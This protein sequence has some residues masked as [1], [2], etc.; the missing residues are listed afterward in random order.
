MLKEYFRGNEVEVGLDEA[1]RGCLCGPVCVAA[2]ILPQ[3]GLRDPP[4]EIK[5]SKK[6]SVKKRGIIRKYLEDNVMYSVQFVGPDIIDEINILQATMKGMHRCLDELCEKTEIE[7][8]LVDGTYFPIYHHKRTFDAISHECFAGG[9]N[10]YQSI[11]AASILAKEYRD[12]YMR[13][14]VE[15]NPRLQDYGIH[16]NQ[17]YGTREHMQALYEKGV[18]PWHRTSFQPCKRLVHS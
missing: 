13:D 15:K 16:T 11:A 3:G 18:T 7:R 8:I 17:G 9:D 1:G 4:Y 12:E 5:D 10:L 2:V 6:M 14:L